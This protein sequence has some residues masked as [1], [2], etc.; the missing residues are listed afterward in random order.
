MMTVSGKG[1]GEGWREQRSKIV[2][3]GI[4]FS[5]H[6]SSASLLSGGSA[7]YA[8]T[9]EDRQSY[10]VRRLKKELMDAR[11]QVLSLSS[12]L[13]TNVSTYTEGINKSKGR[14]EGRVGLLSVY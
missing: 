1:V 2:L 13:N 11:E 5:A 9:Q 4:S 3:N 14:K 7:L 6:G 12:Q 10:E 8:N